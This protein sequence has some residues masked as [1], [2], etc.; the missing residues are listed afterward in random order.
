[1]PPADRPLKIWGK[2]VQ[3]CY[4][5]HIR[6]HS[7]SCLVQVATG[8]PTLASAGF[9]GDQEVVSPPLRSPAAIKVEI[10]QT[11][12]IAAVGEVVED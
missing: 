9:P 2:A 3:R 5:Q 8:E 7:S 6:N 12:T 10:T 4:K 11:V 1:M